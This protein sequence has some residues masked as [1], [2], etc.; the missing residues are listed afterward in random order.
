MSMRGKSK[1][2]SIGL[3]LRDSQKK[4][5]S[6]FAIS[7]LRRQWPEIVGEALSKTTRPKKMDRNILWVS[8]QNS[9]LNYELSLMKPMILEKLQQVSGRS[10]KDIKLIHEPVMILSDVRVVH[11]QKF[12]REETSDGETLDHILSHVRT[13]SKELQEK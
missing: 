1:L 7:S 13:L 11:R 2:T 12:K 3:V 6:V 8:V 10:F 5:Q 4:I 9:A